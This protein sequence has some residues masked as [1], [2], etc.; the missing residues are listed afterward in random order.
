MKRIPILILAIFIGCSAHISPPEQTTPVPAPGPSPMASPSPLVSAVPVVKEKMFGFT[1]DDVS[2][3]PAIIT[4]LKSLPAKPWVRIVFDEGVRAKDYT[5]AVDAIHPYAFIMGELLDSKF[6]KTCDG[7]CYEKRVKEYLSLLPKVDLWELGNEVNGNW[8]GTNPWAKFSNSLKLAKLAGKKTAITFY[9]EKDLGMFPFI[10]KT[11]SSEDKLNI[12]YALIS[13]YAK[14]NDNWKPQSWNAIFEML[15]TLLPNAKLGMGECGDDRSEA[16]ARAE[17]NSFY[18]NF[19]VDSPKFIGGFFWWYT[20]Q[21]VGK[22]AFL[23]E[24]LKA[25]MR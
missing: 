11:L 20:R 3:I 21:L 5:Q 23:L 18:K 4:T 13:F 2:N 22:N 17:F 8:L 25:V 19:P 9:L 16:Q 7:G 14:D 24:D 12:D 10:T 6:V 15:G 1:I